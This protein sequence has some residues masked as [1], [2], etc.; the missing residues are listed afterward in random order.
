[1]HKEEIIEEGIVLRSNDGIAEVAL[2]TGDSCEECTAKIFCKPQDDTNKV[3]TAVDPYS[4]SPGDRVRISIEGK[5]LFSISVLIYGIPLLLLIVG[6]VIG[7][8][9]FK[10]SS[11]SEL[12]S[13]LFSLG[14]IGIYFLAFYN[15]SI[16]YFKDKAMPRIIQVNS[17]EE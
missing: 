16:R 12:Y 5:T 10:G 7:L 2:A 15:I 17:S 13:F 3:L 4:T 11:L 14:L 1:M 9:L 8:N 6:V